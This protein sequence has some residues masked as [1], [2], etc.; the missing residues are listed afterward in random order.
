[1]VLAATGYPA[2]PRKGDAIGPLPDTSE[3]CMIFHAGT[4]VVDGA[5]VTSGGR[6]MAVVGLADTVRFA[7]R[8]AYEVARQVH[9]DGA[10][11][12]TDIGHHALAHVATP[13]RPR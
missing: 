11:F 12:R 8:R 4:Q 13:A 5:L 6:V 10:Q 7:Q 9:F 3:D 1:V 2:S